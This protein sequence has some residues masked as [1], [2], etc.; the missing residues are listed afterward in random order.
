M[1]VCVVI[2]EYWGWEDSES[3]STDVVG[4]YADLERLEY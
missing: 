4:V 1:K 2:K 3:N